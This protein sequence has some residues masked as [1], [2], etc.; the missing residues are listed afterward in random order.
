[1]RETKPPRLMKLASAERRHFVSLTSFR[2]FPL[3]T[4]RRLRGGSR[5]T[6]GSLARTFRV[7]QTSIQHRVQVA[8]WF[9]HLTLINRQCLGIRMQRRA[10][11]RVRPKRRA[12]IPPGCRGGLLPRRLPIKTRVNEPSLS[13]WIQTHAVV[14]AGNERPRRSRSR[15]LEYGPPTVDDQAVSGNKGRSI[16][17]QK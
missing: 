9:D 8:N 16:A 13:R 17:E 5:G 10:R 12:R 3:S 14:D 7:N 6:A 15:A 11:G 4:W 2:R 1:M